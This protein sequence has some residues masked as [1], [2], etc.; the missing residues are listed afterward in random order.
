MRGQAK[1]LV[2]DD[3]KAVRLSLAELLSMEGHQVI[4]AESGEEALQRLEEDNFDLILVDL[5]MPG[6][7]G[8]QV[9]EAAQRLSPHTVVIMLTAHGSLE[10]AIH[11]L[12]QGAHDYL[13]KPC[14]VEEILRSVEG[15]LNKRW[16]AVRRQE[17]MARM[18]ETLWELQAEEQ[19]A[20]AS[21]R[22]PLRRRRFLQARGIVIDSQK[23]LATMH[24]EPLE[25][26]P[27]EFR[28]LT[29]LMENA[30]RVLSCRELVRM[31]QNYDCRE[32]EARAI[33]R[34]HIRRL[35]QK[36]EPDPSNP[37]YIINVR[38]AGYMFVST[39]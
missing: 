5:I 7:D 19:F 35:R 26:T 30:D 3:E 21:R 16:Q 24:G 4:T 1:I 36:I 23:H 6:I 14:D 18:E 15:G 20:P 12:R 38:Q 11:A 17:L 32:Q 33:I 9:M 34:V 2:V 22:E 31:V 10:S 27:T 37:Q 25:L 28:L 13:L 39:P 8:L 29:V